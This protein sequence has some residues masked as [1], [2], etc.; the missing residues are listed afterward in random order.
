MIVAD[1]FFYWFFPW[2]IVL[3]L[4]AYSIVRKSENG[5]IITA[6]TLFFLTFISGMATTLHPTDDFSTYEVIP[7]E[8]LDIAKTETK[9]LITYKDLEY[10]TSD[11]Y[12]YN[13]VKDTSKVKTYLYTGRNSYGYEIDRG[14]ILKR[15]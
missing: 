7:V 1:T 9:A 5:L 12:F 8:K 3:L 2:L 15:N 13:N 4:L 6:L 11:V 14:L 10:I